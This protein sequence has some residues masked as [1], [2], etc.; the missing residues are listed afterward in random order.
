MKASGNADVFARA[1]FDLAS[2]AGAVDET[3]EGVAAVA[4][5]ARGHGG[6][7]EALTD[8]AVPVEKKRAVLRE[9]FGGSATPEAVAIA[10]LAVERGGVELL[11]EVATRYREISEAE[12]GMVVAEVTTAVA[13]D[14]ELRARLQDRLS[15]SLGRPV[16]LRER[17]DGDILG[18]IVIKV[19]GRVLDGS[20]ALQLDEARDRLSSTPAGGEQ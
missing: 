12:R 1:L 19:A 18:G 15:A 14:D 6:L 13:L 2:A 16:S 5:A 11:R 8:T 7:R 10:T 20:L 3:D 17:V 4:A 9:L